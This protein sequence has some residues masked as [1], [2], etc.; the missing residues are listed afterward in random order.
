MY[1]FYGVEDDETK[2]YYTQIVV[3]LAFKSAET[4]FYFLCARDDNDVALQVV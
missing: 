1:E 4:G 2:P 3:V